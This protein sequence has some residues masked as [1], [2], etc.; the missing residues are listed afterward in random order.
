MFSYTRQRKKLIKV[1]W[2]CITLE[3]ICS[4]F[5]N[6]QSS[7]TIFYLNWFQFQIIIITIYEHPLVT[8]IYISKCKMYQIVTVEILSL[9]MKR[10]NKRTFNNISKKVIGAINK[11]FKKKMNW[12]TMVPLP[13]QERS[14][15]TYFS[16]AV[17]GET[18]ND[19]RRYEWLRLRSFLTFP[20]TS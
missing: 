9:L 16:I 10:K 3:I 8:W 2:V 18:V 19:K 20:L 15:D 12:L 5:I 6:F 13:Q 14:V 1:G 17:N 4:F 7:I 11:V